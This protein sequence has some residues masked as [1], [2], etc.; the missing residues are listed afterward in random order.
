LLF[1]LATSGGSSGAGARGGLRSPPG[2]RR[3]LC[4]AGREAAAEKVAGTPPVAY[5]SRAPQRHLLE[6]LGGVAAEGVWRYPGTS[7]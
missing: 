3:L 7:K 4:W 2:M 1:P 5:A 6:N